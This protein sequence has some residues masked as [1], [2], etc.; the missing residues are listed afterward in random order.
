MFRAI[1]GVRDNELNEVTN[2][3]C[4]TV[5]TRTGEFALSRRQAENVKGNLQKSR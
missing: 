3:V 1:A 4:D 5:L 2:E